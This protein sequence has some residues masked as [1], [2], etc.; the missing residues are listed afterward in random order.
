ME[1][2]QII[3]DNQVSNVKID[4]THEGIVDSKILK[5]KFKKPDSNANAWLDVTDPRFASFMMT[6]AFNDFEVFYGI[7]K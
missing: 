1:F 5:D 3:G 4:I 7:I 2:H 6:P